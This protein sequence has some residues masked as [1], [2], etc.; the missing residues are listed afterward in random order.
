D[1]RA[2]A[3]AFRAHGRRPAGAGALPVR[4]R[5]CRL[6]ERPAARAARP[7]RDRGAGGGIFRAPA[8]QLCPRGGLAGADD[9]GGR[10][11]GRVAG[12]PRRPPTAADAAAARGAAMNRIDW[13]IVRRLLGSIGLTLAVLYGLVLLVESLNTS[14]F[15]ALMR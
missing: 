7:D 11:V 9:R 8:L 1:R 2:A 4:R 14:R 5:H 12:D 3:Q 15:M 10:P 13:V 6:S